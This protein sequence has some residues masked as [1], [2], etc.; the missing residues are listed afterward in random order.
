MNLKSFFPTHACTAHIE[1]FELLEKEG[2]YSP[3]HIP[4]LNDVSNFLKRKYLLNNYNLRAP[5]VSV[6]SSFIVLAFYCYGTNAE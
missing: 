3:N 1:N 6:S 4:Q 2:I 5:T